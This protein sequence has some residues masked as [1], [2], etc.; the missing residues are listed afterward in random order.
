VYSEACVWGELKITI[1]SAEFFVRK[2]QTVKTQL[3]DWK[4][5]LRLFIFKYQ[6]KNGP[7]YHV[8]DT[9]LLTI[10]VFAQREEEVC[11]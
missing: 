9:S 8:S 7:T 1:C 2:E 4:L 3:T 11:G 6:K 10:Q 5:C